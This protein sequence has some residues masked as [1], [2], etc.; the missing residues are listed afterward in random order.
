MIEDEARIAASIDEPDCVGQFAGA[1]AKVVAQPQFAKLPDTGDEVAIVLSPMERTSPVLLEEKI[2]G[3]FTDEA[4]EWFD[5][6]PALSKTI[7]GAPPTG[8]EAA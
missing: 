2:S 8:R 6:T 4:G 1:H 5:V 7:A 3:R